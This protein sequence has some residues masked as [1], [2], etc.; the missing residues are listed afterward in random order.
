[1]RARRSLS[2]A[3]LLASSFAT[4]FAAASETPRVLTI[5]AAVTAARKAQPDV[6]RARAQLEA[7]EARV[8]QASSAYLPRVDAQAQY[9]RSTANLAISP[10]FSRSP[11]AQAARSNSLD[12]VNYYQ[13]GITASETIYDFGRTGGGV[14]AAEAGQKVARADLDTTGRNVDLAVRVAYFTVLATKALVFIGG[15]TARNQSKHVSQ[16]QQFVAAGTRPKIDLTSANLNLANVELSLV[17]AQNALA[18]AKVRLNAAMGTEGSIDYDV[19]APEAKTVVGEE[20]EVERLMEEALSRRPEM[21]RIEARVLAA[22]AQVKSVRSA[23]YPAL[24]ASAAFNG[25]TVGSLA[26]GLNAFIGVG[27]AWNLFGGFATTRQVEE[28]EANLRAIAADRD[29]LRLTIRSE[30]EGDGLAV[31]EAK[32]RLEVAERAVLAAKERL[33]LAEG[34]YDA[35]AGDVLELDDAQVTDANAKAQ[36]VEA[37]YDLA[38]ARARLSHALGSEER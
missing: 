31:K 32:R 3:V 7:S 33:Q 4:R 10:Q 5:E 17:R 28:V 23:F 25:A 22:E 30:L 36:R 14:E 37:E 19:V 6:T 1:M 13:F 8:G 2:L 35:G 18:L 34:R 27:L 20:G 38:I 9:Q 21:R 26:F 11:L 24:V 16:I 29:A 12:S 15:E